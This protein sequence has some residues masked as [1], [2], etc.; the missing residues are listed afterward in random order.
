MRQY[1]YCQIFLFQGIHI[2]ISYHASAYM[3][4]PQSLARLGKGIR[5]FS[6]IPFE[7]IHSLRRLAVLVE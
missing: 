6:K 2:K 3:K 1:L 7:T 4:A 5:R